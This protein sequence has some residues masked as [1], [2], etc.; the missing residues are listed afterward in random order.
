MVYQG[1]TQREHMG[2]FPPYA[3][4]GPTEAAAPLEADECGLKRASNTSAKGRLRKDLKWRLRVPREPNSD[5]IGQF[6][7]K[8]RVFLRLKRAPRLPE[9]ALCGPG[10]L[11]RSLST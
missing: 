10:R 11:E 1:R 8:K 2:L 6:Q 7:S 9:R 3:L 5:L 4:G